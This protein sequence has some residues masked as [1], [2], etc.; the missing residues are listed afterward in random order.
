MDLLTIEE[1]AAMLKLSPFTVGQ[2]LREGKLP[3]RKIGRHWRVL[4]SELE[5]FIQGSGQHTPDQQGGT[6]NAERN[7]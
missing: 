1:V 2:Y 5:Q 6:D 3:G 7:P 4:R